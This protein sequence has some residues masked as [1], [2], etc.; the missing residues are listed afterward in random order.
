MQGV[1]KWDDSVSISIYTVGGF[2]VGLGF[3]FFSPFYIDDLAEEMWRKVR[4]FLLTQ[5]WG[6]E[7]VNTKVKSDIGQKV[8]EQTRSLNG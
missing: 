6:G 2:F 7:P 3:R 1:G 5:K 4:Q 8:L